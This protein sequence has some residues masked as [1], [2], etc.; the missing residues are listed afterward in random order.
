M[1]YKASDIE[2]DIVLDSNESPFDIPRSTKER[3]VK[4]IYDGGYLTIS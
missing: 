3:L 1:P 4:Y 2:Y